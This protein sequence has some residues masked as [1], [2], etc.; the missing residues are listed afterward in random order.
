MNVVVNDLMTNYQKSGNGKAL[1]F[2]H[3]WGEGLSSFN[4]ITKELEDDFTVLRLDLP[5]MGAT[6]APET[7]WGLEDY[8]KFVKAW[9]DK[10]NTSDIYGLVGHSNGGAISIY[11]VANNLLSP[12]KLVLLSSSGH[13][14]KHRF[15]RSLLKASSKTGK[16]ITRP[17]P[18]STR[19]RLR[20]KLYTRIGSDVGL[21]PQM[22]ETFR[23]ITRQ[24]VQ[25]DARVIKTPTLIIYGDKDKTTPPLYGELF[26]DQISNSKLE[27]IS[28]GG[29]FI[30][31]EKPRDVGNIIN[32]FLK[33]GS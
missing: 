12:K 20:N 5:G 9:L 33:N 11:A 26:H 28:G 3:G 29:H 23:K 1:V 27:I 2:L 17:L 14:D 30:H 21:F 18:H 13:R 15:K 10:I 6:Q 8:S 4:A 25:N 19:V 31:Q 24:D 16:I 32:D 7:A 22:E